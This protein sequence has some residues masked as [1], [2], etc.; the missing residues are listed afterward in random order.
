M[1]VL[2]FEGK[3]NNKHTIWS[4]HENFILIPYAQ[5]PPY[6]MHSCISRVIKGLKYDLG[7]HVCLWK[8]CYRVCSTMR[9][10]IDSFDS[11]YLSFS[12]IINQSAAILNN[13]TKILSQ[14]PQATP[15]H[16]HTNHYQTITKT[17]LASSNHSLSHHTHQQH[18]PQCQTVYTWV[19]TQYFGTYRI[20]TILSLP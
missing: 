5:M 7:L 10:N 4:E 17:S 19:C 20:C 6:S 3:S 13:D 16:T 1:S 8:K 14:A 18:T 15:P 11:I 2:W 9:Y 12:Q